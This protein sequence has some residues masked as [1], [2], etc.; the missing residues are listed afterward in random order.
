MNDHEPLSAEI[1][2]E[3][4]VPQVVVLTCPV[5]LGDGY[6]EHPRTLS[7]HTCRTC[8]GRGRIATERGEP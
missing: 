4:T 6:V 8:A 3:P 5:C 1:T 7:T 2:G